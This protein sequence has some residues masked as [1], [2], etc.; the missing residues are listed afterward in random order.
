M[1]LKE[2]VKKRDFK[3]TAEPQGKPKK[4]A[5]KTSKAKASPLMFVVQEHHASHLHY[6]FRL[7]WEGVLK[8]W[9]VPKGP[10]LDPATKRLA[11]EVEDHPLEYGKFHG[12]I[13]EDE[14]GGG[15]VY[16]WDTGTWVPEID[17]AAGFKKGHLEFTLKGKK[18]KGS[19]H[20]VRTRMQGSKYQWLLMKSQD[21]FTSKK[22]IQQ[23]ATGKKSSTSSKSKTLKKKKALPDFIEPQLAQLV[24]EAPEGK[25]WIHE[26]KFDGYRMQSHLHDGDVKIFT[27]SGLDWTKK[28]PTIAKA[29]GEINIENAI[30]DG[31]MVVVEE[32]GRTDFQKLQNA[33]KS[34]DHKSMYY[35]IFDL[36]FLN[37]E[38]LRSLPLI[39]R[40]KKLKALLSKGKSRVRYSDHQV[41]GGDKLYA[42]ACDIK[43]EGII[44]KDGQSTYSSGRRD[45]WRKVKCGMQQEFVIG[46]YSEGQ[47]SRDQMFGALL[48]GVYEGK[49]LRYV[50]KVGTGFTQK[51]LKEI[52]K[53]LLP[54]EQDES[55]FQIGSPKARGLHWLK[56]KKSAEITFGNWTEDNHLR[57]PVFHGLREDKKS[58]EIKMEK[59]IEMKS[60]TKTTKAKASVGKKK[61][62]PAGAL[63]LSSPDKVLFQEEGL[64][65]LDLAKFYLTIANDILPHLE[66]RPLSLMRCPEGT[67]K[68]CFFQKHV[69]GKLGEHLN[70][71]M[72]KEKSGKQS[73]V[74]ID[75]PEA[76][77]DLVQMGA[78]EIHAWNCRKEDV[79]APDQIVMDFDPGPGVG[80][81]Q[82]VQGA[83]DLKK[84]LDRLKIKSFVKVS[85]S[86]GL[87]VHIPLK[88][89]HSWDEVK[90][91]AHTLALI[92][93]EQ[94]PDLYVSKMSKSL[95]QG[96]IFVDYLRNGRGATAVVPYSLRAR[97]L[98]AVAMPVEWSEIS[99]LKG[100]NQFSL[101]KALAHLR[102][103]K[104]DPW[105]DFFKSAQKLRALASA[106]PARPK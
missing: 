66:D 11:V 72:I 63:H 24:S 65:K 49:K 32:D 13:P 3:K 38:D 93:E 81:K 42:Q 10:S 48:L 56:P 18:L 84:I 74:V 51:S 85:G 4:K 104:K 105:K 9:A 2:Y 25:D 102:K 94:S 79:E 21:A 37:G 55:P 41:G 27:R 34:A 47:G 33:I 45:S 97:D 96:K 8:S 61:S 60:T 90:D 17:P 29:L 64:T 75:R 46:G 22:P 31:E 40:K 57:V 82:V 19:W 92:L 43:L 71:I 7:E 67:G 28:F 83:M 50:G 70:E 89:V 36:L 12:Q 78:F 35:Y 106:R 62:L 14:Y 68:A 30:F 5:K 91:F 101:P 88:P 39:E 53:V 98:S 80:W 87:H 77:V 69:H 103:R 6:D 95:R 15:D 54:L 58:S 100:A 59:P 44:S 52:Q 16:I 73:Y 23:M 76:L 1:S 99:K 20:L 86:K 26:V